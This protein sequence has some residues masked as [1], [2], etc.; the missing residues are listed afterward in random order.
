M[1]E[2]AATPARPP[3]RGGGVTPRLVSTVPDMTVTPRLVRL[4]A[5]SERWPPRRCSCR[6]TCG[7]CAVGLGPVSWVALG[8]CGGAGPG[9]SNYRVSHHWGGATLLLGAPLHPKRALD[10]SRRAEEV[11]PRSVLEG[12]VWLEHGRLANHA[13]APLRNLRPNVRLGTFLQ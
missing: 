13:R 10:R 12:G 4:A 5:G 9:L 8:R 1:K 7:G 11:S 2:P 6:R 3:S